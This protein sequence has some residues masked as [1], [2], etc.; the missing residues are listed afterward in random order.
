[1]R[2]FKIENEKID[3]TTT[4]DYGKDVVNKAKYDI[5]PLACFVAEEMDEEML[6]G[7][8]YNEICGNIRHAQLNLSQLYIAVLELIKEGKI[9]K[10][11]IN[12]WDDLM[13]IGN[14][15]GFL[16]KL[17]NAFQG[18]TISL[19]EIKVITQKS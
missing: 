18:I 2:D 9:R 7:S 16:E 10:I 1:M 14:Q 13:F 8:A 11:D 17:A 4:I 5:Y 15:L 3:F 12:H 19:E 6:A